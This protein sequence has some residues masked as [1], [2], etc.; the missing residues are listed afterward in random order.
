MIEID[1]N[2]DGIIDMKE[3]SLWYFTGMKAYDGKSK[4]MLQMKNQIGTIF[5]LLAKEGIEEI[6]KEDKTLNTHKIKIQI[7]EPSPDHYLEVITH[8]LGPHTEKMVAISDEYIKELGDDVSLHPG[9]KVDKIYMQ[10]EATMKPGGK[11]KYE[12]MCKKLNEFYDY[13]FSTNKG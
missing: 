2:G 5:D 12:E 11:A 9:K 13:S 7:N 4:S 8:L 6:I 3:F 1:K 10:A